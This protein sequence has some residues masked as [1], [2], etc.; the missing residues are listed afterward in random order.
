LG[1]PNTLSNNVSQL[2]ETL[3]G[4]S[5]PIYTNYE[6]DK[7]NRETKVTINN[8]G[9]LTSAYDTLGRLTGK[10]ANTGTTN[11]NTSYSYLAGANGSSTEK[12]GSITNNGTAISYTYDGNNN[13]STII[14]G[15]QVISY[16]YNELNEVIRENNQ[17]LNKTFTYSYDAGGNIAS[18]KEYAYTTGTL[19]T[20]TKTINYSYGDS[21]WKDKL[22]SYDG[23]SI[24]YDANGNPMTYDGWT[25]TWESGRQLKTSNGN[26]HS[27]TYKY[28]DLG[29]RT[30]KVVDGVT[31]NYHLVG[32]K[33]TYESNGTDKIYYTYDSSN[34]L[35][36]MN[37]NGTEYYYIR[38][39]QGDII[40]L[41]D[42]AGT[43][44]VS[45]TYNMWGKLISTTG[46]LASTVGV[47]NP[48]RYR[49]YRYDTE[50]QLY[51]LQ[52]RYYNPEWGRFINADSLIGEMGESLAHNM[53]A[54]T[55]NNPVN[56]M[57]P[58]GE[59]AAVAGIYLIPGIGEV[60][61]AATG[62]IIVGGVVLWTGSRLATTI[63]SWVQTWGQSQIYQA[64]KSI[65]NKLKKS[66]KY[67]DLSKF[68]QKKPGNG[69]P[70]WVGPIGWYIQ[71]DMA[72]HGERAWK[73][74]NWA[75]D[76]VAS[77]AKDGK[78]LGK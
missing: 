57:D 60:A 62:A 20:P 68:N 25:Y 74:F 52:S 33:V 67:V 11:Y 64:S 77:L 72:G 45:Y 58:T 2:T 41:F 5:N 10:T 37:L 15:G 26:G 48:Y 47:K 31:T 71:K 49:G 69:P 53:F 66:D 9:Y 4:Q 28:D 78:I 40:G 43:Q 24:T 21:N 75:G 54:Y 29:I 61:L 44:V 59:C 42:S 65:P 1:N 73:L 35:V 16:Q 14:Q 56:K 27:I 17:V 70:T 51:Y 12:V 63:R 13:I 76:R 38:N 55:T 50:T 32:D 30:Q 23:K 3:L 46:S 36:S 39:A 19:G 22:T 34:N 6:Y 8:G 7:D 18:K